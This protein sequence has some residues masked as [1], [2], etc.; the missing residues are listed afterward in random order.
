MDH[1]MQQIK[2]SIEIFS[3]LR[4]VLWEQASY[5]RLNK[6]N[7]NMV[8]VNSENRIIWMFVRSN[9]FK[10]IRNAKIS[11]EKNVCDFYFAIC[12]CINMD[13]TA[14]RRSQMKND[15]FRNEHEL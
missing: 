4:S 2:N 14:V 10:I 6:K 1:I 15:F 12:S 3:L 11:N 8:S 9:R 5:Y 7:H 13:F